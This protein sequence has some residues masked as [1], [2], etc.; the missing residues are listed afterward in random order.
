VRYLQ[1]ERT[2]PNKIIARVGKLI[3]VLSFAI[4]AVF[5]YFWS[6]GGSVEYHMRPLGTLSPSAQLDRIGAL[7]ERV[8]CELWGRP[9][10]GGDGWYA[11]YRF[12]NEIEDDLATCLRRAS[13]NEFSV[14]KASWLGTKFHE[15]TRSSM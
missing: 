11:Q 1:S 7:N 15:L 12:P 5:V 14:E 2:L 8:G 9:T 6:V 3:V 10:Q 13:R 4:S